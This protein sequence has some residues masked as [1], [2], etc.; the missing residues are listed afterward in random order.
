MMKGVGDGVTVGVDVG[1]V[2]VGDSV[3]D[4]VGVCTGVNS[5]TSVAVAAAA[6][7]CSGGISVGVGDGPTVGGVGITMLGSMPGGTMI[8]PG[9]P[10]AG[11]VTM[12]SVCT[13]SGV[14]VNVGANVPTIRG[15]GVARV[16]VTRSA[17]E[18]PV[19]ISIDKI[20]IRAE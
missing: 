4:G 8:T 2:G 16:R 11:G 17:A 19:H 5:A 9:S 20:S 7:A 13:A 3:R 14:G 15:V 1:C 10:P 12:T 6:V 18:Q